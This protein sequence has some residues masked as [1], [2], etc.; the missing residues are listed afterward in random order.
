MTNLYDIKADI[1][2]LLTKGWDEQCIDMETGEIDEA[3]VADLLAKLEMDEQEKIEN[4]ACFIKNLDA[5]SA[6]IRAEEKVLAERRRVK[7]NKAA[8]LRRYLGSYLQGRK[9]ET[10]RCVVSVRKSEAVEITDMEAVIN[11]AKKYGGSLLK[12][13]EPEVNKN[14][15]K[16]I[17]KDGGFIKGAQLVK[18]QNLQI[19]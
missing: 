5:Y 19:K 4:V 18:R 3:K 17:L 12:T 15:L 8:S 2:S 6:A 1:D 10:P 9:S 13:P 14:E 16:L 11:F 7:E